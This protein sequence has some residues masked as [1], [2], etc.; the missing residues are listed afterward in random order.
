MSL[1]CEQTYSKIWCCSLD[2]E[3][4]EA[5]YVTAKIQWRRKP[6]GTLTCI[7]FLGMLL[8]KVDEAASIYNIVP[9]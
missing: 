4:V 6:E 8:G 5:P 9:K 1:E 2:R 7:H 3:D